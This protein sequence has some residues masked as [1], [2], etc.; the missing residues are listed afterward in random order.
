MSGEKERHKVVID[1]KGE[2]GVYM[3]IKDRGRDRRCEI[4]VLLKEEERMDVRATAVEITQS[5]GLLIVTT[6]GFA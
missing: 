5:R 3:S 2:R 4:K 1:M 6:L